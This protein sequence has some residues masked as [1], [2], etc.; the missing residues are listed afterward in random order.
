MKTAFDSDM[1]LRFFVSLGGGV[2][3][4]VAALSLAIALFA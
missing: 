2:F 4:A 3:L 1:A